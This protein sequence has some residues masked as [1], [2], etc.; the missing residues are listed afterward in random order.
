MRTKSPEEISVANLSRLSVCN[1]VT[2]SVIPGGNKV[3]FLY[4]NW[5]HFIIR[6]VVGSNPTGP[7]F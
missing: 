5:D 7:I 3:R 1:V 6:E 4:P 2:E